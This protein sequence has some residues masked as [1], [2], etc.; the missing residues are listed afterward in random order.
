MKITIDT[1][2]DSHEE[3]SKVI[4]MLQHLVG[5]S[6]MTNQPTNIFEDPDSFG[7]E[8]VQE[9]TQAPETEPSSGGIFSMFGNASEPSG[10]EEPAEEPEEKD[11]PPEI[12]PY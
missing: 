4:K 3:I 9:Q 8:Q 12:I 6:S 11:D 7:Q 10:S 5:E 1:K 2:E